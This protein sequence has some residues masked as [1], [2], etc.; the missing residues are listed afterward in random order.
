M[1]RHRLIHVLLWG[2][3]HQFGASVTSMAD[4]PR[5]GGYYEGKEEGWFWREGVLEAVIDE[6]PIEIEQGKELN[7]EVSLPEQLVGPRPL[8]PEW[9]R[10]KLPEYRDRALEYPTQDNVRAYF[11]LQRHAMNVA[12]RFARVAQQVVLSDPTLDENTRRPISSYG[13]HVFDEVARENRLRVAMKIAS[14]AGVWYFYRS[15]CPYCHAQNPVLE[16]L[17]RRIG[18]AVLPIALD[19]RAMPEARFSGY[20]PD[21]GHAQ[22]LGVTQTPTLYLVR[23]GEFVLLSEGL[24]TDDGLMERIVHAG[25]DAGWIT[26]EEFDSTRAARPAG[27]IVS[28]SDVTDELLS[29]PAK[30]VE[31][32]QARDTPLR[33]R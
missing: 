8:S 16:R 27:Q 24:V 13:G 18:L 3:I 15:D 9:M 2:V 10:V 7:V 29:D 20:V 14:M 32:L 19:D 21:R 26:D 12:E 5:H 4:E 17:Q 25:H 33:S 30:L 31:F 11:Y 23:P 22:E 28:A 6:A 1:E